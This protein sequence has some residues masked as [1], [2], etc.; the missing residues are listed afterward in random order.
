MITFTCPACKKKLR[1]K[2]ELA[3][4]RVKCPSCQKPVAIPIPSAAPVSQVQPRADHIADEKTLPPRA[5][6]GAAAAEPRPKNLAGKES[7]SDAEGQTALGARRKGEATQS[8]PAEGANPELYDFLAPAQQPDEIGRLGG[9]RILQ[10]LGAG[11]MGVVFLAEDPA[12][13]R[14]V[15]LKAML[16][17]LA[18]SATAKQRFLRE[19]QTAAAIEHDHIVAIHQ[20]GEDR[21]VPFIAMPFLKGEPLDRRLDR[22]PVLPVADILRIGREASNGLAAAHAA[23]LV[24]RDIKPANLW[25]ESFPGQPGASAPECRLKILDFGLARV[26]TDN[27]GLTQQG[28][29][30]G[31]PAFM[32][33]EQAAG[34]AVDGRCDLFSLGCVLY[35][36]CTGQPPFTGKDTISI[37][38]AVALEHPRPPVEL[39][40]ELPEALSA[41]VMR[42]L[43]KKPEE[44]PESARVVAEALRDIET[45]LAE[46]ATPPGPRSQRGPGADTPRLEAARSPA[47]RSAKRRFPLPWLVGGGV[48]G[49]GI[50]GLLLFILVRPGGNPVNRG[51]QSPEGDAPGAEPED[52]PPAPGPPACAAEALQREQVTEAA[53]ANL[54]Q[55]D[56]NAAPAELVAVLGDAR[57]RLAGQT[58]FPVFSPDGAWLAAANGEDVRL[59][60]AATGRWW[61][62]LR[63]HRGRVRAVAIAPNGK[64]VATGNDATVCMWDR[65]TGRLL[66]ALPGHTGF[67]RNL[68]FSP[69]GTTLASAGDDRVRVWSVPDGRALQALAGSAAHTVAFSSDGQWLAAGCTDGKVRLWETKGYTLRHTLAHDG[70]GEWAVAFSGDG[71]WLATG[72][73]SKL[74]LWDAR[75]IA[76]PTVRLHY[77]RNASA[78][79]LAFSPDGT[80][81][82]TGKRKGATDND[83]RR[84]ETATGKEMVV[85][86]LA[87]DGMACYALSPDGATVAGLAEAD[88][89]VQFWDART[90]QPRVAEFGHRRAV[91]SV[92]FSPDGRSLASGSD[93]HSVRVW[94]L[95]TAKQRHLLQAHARPVWSVAYSSDGKLLASG[96]LDGTIML[97]DAGQGQRVRVLTGHCREGTLIAFSPDGRL[98]AAG[99]SDGGILFWNARTGEAERKLPGL[100]QGLVRCVAF[101]SDGRRIASCGRDGKLLVSDVSSGAALAQATAPRRPAVIVRLSA[102]GE[103]VATGGDGP[104]PLARLWNPQAN[105]FV[106][107]TGHA[108]AVGGLAFR[109]DG[110]LLATAS[111][112]DS[113]RLWEVGGDHPRR[114]V[115]GMGCFG[116]G[117]LAVEFSTD[118]R[119][120]AAA[121][122]DGTIGLF[123]LAAPAEQIGDWMQSRACPPPPGLPHGEWLK[124]IRGLSAGNQ[125]QAVSDRLC[126]LNPGFDGVVRPTIDHGVV[127]GV[128]VWNE[129][130]VDVT[131]LAAL[132]GLKRFEAVGPYNGGFGKNKLSD[133]SPLKGLPLERIDVGAAPV[134]D[135]KFVR[136][137]PLKYVHLF[138]TRV[139]DLEPLRGMKLEDLNIAAGPVRDL[140]PLEGM[141]LKALNCWFARGVHDLKPLHGMPLTYL[142]LGGTAVKD[143]SP[144]ADSP[145]EFLDCGGTRITELGPLRGMPLKTLRIVNTRVTRLDALAQLPL[146]DFSCEGAPVTDLSPLKGL[147]LRVLTCDFVPERD[148]P[149]LRGIKTLEK[150]NGKSAAAFWKEV[151]AKHPPARP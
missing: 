48:L 64:L 49:V 151:E 72:G 41:L 137:M 45:Q 56:P 39:R 127:T 28:A 108:A 21:G 58:R 132:P 141:P 50:L 102:G 90:G 133:L 16:P 24:H 37:L 123:R 46:G 144:L 30:L 117:P 20:V 126:E 86:P 113:V 112:D 111:L 76:S 27:A 13:K 66:A 67:L 121:N 110:R 138:C 107:L 115:L 146:E 97:W 9:Y 15:A 3:G 109:P 8:V 130:L 96:S 73:N 26:A 78:G 43:A 18:A 99:T 124:R 17:A 75:T 134:A 22:E 11:G 62:S 12:L 128:W 4:K 98:V 71:K 57:F 34:Q 10:V 63:E 89:V 88:R 40:Q 103:W 83:V 87:G 81:V 106:N 91:R 52:R 150:I 77:E 2:D 101:S 32:A 51:R 92:A 148:A 94:D 53:L 120:L 23:D 36:M 80:F 116:A 5:P 139:A 19:A 105:D 140:A 25:L 85:M 7:L 70:G 55:A 47:G 93:D 44:R 149:I 60:D 65:E 100:H 143:L 122:A 38:V 29:I 31:T 68:A 135:L 54:G 14:K 35:R 147:P 82:F 114:F 125:V 104:E 61:S 69:A 136:G 142:N 74:K 84:W 1:V 59:F 42:L 145:L 118:G 33:P 129:F 131:P 79:W 6:V 95:A 119:Y